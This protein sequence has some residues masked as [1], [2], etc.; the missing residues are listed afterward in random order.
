MGCDQWRNLMQ[1]RTTPSSAVALRPEDMLP[2][3]VDRTEIGGVVVRK[4][5]VGA[6]LQNAMRW[7]DPGTT[8]VKREALTRE[9]VVSVPALRAL[10]VFDVFDVRD[11]GLR[12]LISRC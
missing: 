7:S 5:T 1:T 3:D 11:E 2:D 8:D 10:G 4:G 9:I 12:K 6:F